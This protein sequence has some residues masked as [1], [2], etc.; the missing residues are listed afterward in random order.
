MKAR[1]FV[2]LFAM[3]VVGAM[4]AVIV[5]ARYFQPETRVVEVPVENKM[6]YVNLPDAT[7]G[8]GLDFTQAVAQSLD[9][10]VHVKTKVFREY[11]VNP[12]YEFFFG[13]QPRGEPA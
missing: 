9:A 2:G 7:D 4:I 13:D 12:L 8:S 10:V 5:Y 1:R 11:A 6:K 3:S